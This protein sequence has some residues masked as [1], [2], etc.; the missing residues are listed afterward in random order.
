MRTKPG[1]WVY[2]LIAVIALMSFLTFSE[3]FYP[4]LNSD[5]AVNILMTPG[6]KFP[7]DIYFWGQDRS[8]SLI[9][10]LAHFL[11]SVTAWQPVIIV[12][13]VH[14][15]ILTAG[16]LALCRF[17]KSAPGRLFTAMFWFFPPWH[18]LEFLLILYGV[19]ASC[20]YIGMNFFDRSWHSEVQWK[21]LAWLSASCMIFIVAVWVSDMIVV[22]LLALMATF[23]AYLLAVHKDRKQ[24][25]S[26][27]VLI[28]PSLL[29]AIWALSGYF[30]L[31]Y[32]KVISVPVQVYNAGYLANPSAIAANMNTVMHSFLRVFVFSS[33]SWIESIY[34][35]SLLAGF[36]MLVFSVKNSWK[37]VPGITKNPWFYFFLLEAIFTLAAVMSSSWV[38]SNGA[39]RRYFTTI[40][41]S[42]WICFI[43][44]LENLPKT[45]IKNRLQIVFFI[46]IIAGSLSGSSRF[47]FPEIRPSRI[48]VL[49]ALKYMGNIGIIA[50]YWNSYMSASPDPFHIKATPHDKDYVRNPELVTEVFNQP[51][52]YL[53]KDGWLESF[54]DSIVQFGRI[55]K[56][57]GRPVHIADAWLNRY[58]VADK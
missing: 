26:L 21:R 29:A 46:V 53:I 52:I 31:R 5:M 56:R 49:S 50:E 34:A 57:T 2:A 41:I 19:Q 38:A 25:I 33:E 24:N 42:S 55:L 10:L 8:G 22:S 45:V 16:F 1:I 44:W 48:H 17:V 7:H 30:M 11:Y 15:S 37:T 35:W 3:N 39:G 51:S 43:I 36:L 58:K 54:P 18:F 6:F 32:A 12:S 40:F 4:L 28:F 27:K 47:Y 13:L 23:V 14:Y 20:V 9:P